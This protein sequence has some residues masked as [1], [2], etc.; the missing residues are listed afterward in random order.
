MKTSIR[1][2]NKLEIRTV[3]DDVGT[4]W[5]FPVLDVVGAINNEENYQ[6]TRNYWKYLRSKLKKDGCQLVPATTKLKLR[7]HDGKLHLTNCVDFDGVVALA[8]AIPDSRAT[9][10]L[11]W[12]IYS[13]EPRGSLRGS[14][15]GRMYI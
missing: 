5:F 4:K 9:A 15:R 2:F 7:A 8:R 10:F 12:F 13:F 1:F 3:W 6:R 11:D 14:L